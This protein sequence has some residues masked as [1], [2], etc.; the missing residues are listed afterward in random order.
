MTNTNIRE[1]ARVCF[2]HPELKLPFLA[3]IDTISLCGRYTKIVLT[4]W[5]NPA[6][7]GDPTE[8]EL[9][10]AADAAIGQ[11]WNVSVRELA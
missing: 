3:R 11:D 6:F 2:Q 4:G 1:G 9:H 10:E 8:E 7:N 5:Y